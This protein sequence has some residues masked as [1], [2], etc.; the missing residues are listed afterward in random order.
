MPSIIQTARQRVILGLRFE[1][2]SPKFQVSIGLKNHQKEKLRNRGNLSEFPEYGSDE[3]LYFLCQ[4][5][6][7]FGISILFNSPLIQLQVS[8]MK[9]L[10][11]RAT[12]N[13]IF[14]H[15]TRH[16]YILIKRFLES[17]DTIPLFA[18]LRSK[19]FSLLPPY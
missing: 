19:S 3:Y 13:F 12:V 5:F 9:E 16:D 10:W 2:R 17:Y 15:R 8:D 14:V 7:K 4:K 11:S 1:R 6:P 18:F